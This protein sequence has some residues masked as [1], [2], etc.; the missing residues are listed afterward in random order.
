MPSHHPPSTT[1][2]T[3][4]SS[5]FSN[6]SYTVHMYMYV[7]VRMHEREMTVYTMYQTPRNEELLYTSL[8]GTGDWGYKSC[9]RLFPCFEKVPPFPLVHKYKSYTMYMYAHMYIQHS[10]VVRAVCATCACTCTI[11]MYMHVQ[12][13]CIYLYDRCV[14]IQSHRHGLHIPH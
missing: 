7:H 14:G 13:I 11:Y 10:S 12:C 5:P 4:I 2:V 8:V 1:L 3:V 6:C 9:S